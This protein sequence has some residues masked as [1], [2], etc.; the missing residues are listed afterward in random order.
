MSSTADVNPVD[1]QLR[2]HAM[3]LQLNTCSGVEAGGPTLYSHLTKSNSFFPFHFEAD[4][5]FHLFSLTLS[6]IKLK[7]RGK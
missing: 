7:T 2:K 5:V 6:L 4:V 1:K 3:K